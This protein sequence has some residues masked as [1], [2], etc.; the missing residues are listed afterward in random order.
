MSFTTALYKILYR[1]RTAY[2]R[3]PRP[4]PEPAGNV[5]YASALFGKNATGTAAPILPGQ[6]ESPTEPGPVEQHFR[7][8]PNER[9]CADLA[10]LAPPPGGVAFQG[11][12]R[13]V[14]TGKERLA[15][16]NRSGRA[17]AGSAT[18]PGQARKRRWSLWGSVSGSEPDSRPLSADTSDCSRS[19]SPR[20]AAMSSYP[21]RSAPITGQLSDEAATP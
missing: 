11:T 10:D 6:R 2:R 8:R 20:S 21:L 15:S 1:K 5:G 4:P 9:P 17:A 14:R 3:R 7:V 18:Q 12:F 19:L 16:G 13:A